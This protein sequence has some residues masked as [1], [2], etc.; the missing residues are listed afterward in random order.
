MICMIVASTKEGVIGNKNSLPWRIKEELQF[1]KNTTKFTTLLM[2]YNTY[3]SLPGKLHD[4]EIIVLTRKELEN[5]KTIKLDQID[6]LFKSFA[7]NDKKLFIAG[8]KQLYEAFYNK[9]EVIYHSVIKKNY[10]GDT[11]IKLDYSNYELS[12]TI[13]EKE[14]VVNIYH[15]KK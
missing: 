14:F 15:R 12:K 2:G 13:N 7:N 9:A 8:G 6:N 3:M 10:E 5:V 11:T 1:F 4:R